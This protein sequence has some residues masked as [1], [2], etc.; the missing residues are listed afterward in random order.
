MD[1][2]SLSRVKYHLFQYIQLGI[3]REL[4]HSTPAIQI[5]HFSSM[6]MKPCLSAP[7]S[8]QVFI[9]RKQKLWSLFS[10]PKSSHYSGLPPQWDLW[11][12]RVSFGEK[13]KIAHQGEISLTSQFTFKHSSASRTSAFHLQTF[14]FILLSQYF[15]FP[16]S[17][18]CISFFGLK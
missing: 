8:F 10:F 14:I 11:F 15:K 17:H 13:E 4:A 9:I 7:Q 12:N 1:R 18:Q 3:P 16:K 6:V 5:N 2:F